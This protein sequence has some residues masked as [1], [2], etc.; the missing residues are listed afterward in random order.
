MGEGEEE[1]EGDE[2]E[3]QAEVDMTDFNEDVGL[4]VIA[5]FSKKLTTRN[6]NKK[7]FRTLIIPYLNL[8]VVASLYRFQPS[9]IVGNS[10]PVYGITKELLTM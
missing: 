3:D 1:K 9:I 6:M 4:K 7:Q 2:E 5:E 8:N 10:V